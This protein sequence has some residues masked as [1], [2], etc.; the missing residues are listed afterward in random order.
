MKGI[1]MVSLESVRRLSCQ[2]LAALVALAGL[3]LP[4]STALAQPNPFDDYERGVEPPPFPTAD[5]EGA[6][7]PGEPG[8]PVEPSGAVDYRASQF[9]WGVGLGAQFAYTGTTNQTLVGHDVTNRTLFARLTPEGRVFIL[10]N[11]EIG[12]SL[13][14]LSKLSAREQDT[15]ATE[16]NFLFEVSGYNHFPVGNGFALVPGVGIGGY[17]GGSARDLTLPNGTSAEESTS[18]SGFNAT[19]HL[20]AAS[21]PH[22][23]WRLRSG[24]TFGL[25][26]GSE[27]V[28]SQ[29]ASLATSAAHIGLPFELIYVF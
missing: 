10:D 19:L 11:L 21:Q 20:T 2:G 25:L 18:T 9:D 23:N 16:N 6:E 13:G 5:E 12:L 28:E 8:E 15:Q 3:S 14:L 17:F 7:G 22:E 4:G 29:D 1:P 24:L 26:A 27:Y